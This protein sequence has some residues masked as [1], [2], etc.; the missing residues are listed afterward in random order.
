MEITTENPFR[1]LNDRLARLE[2]TLDEIKANQKKDHVDPN[3]LL[4]RKQIK[5]SYNISYPTLHKLMHN[6]FPY[7]KEGRKTLFRKGDVDKYFEN[8]KVVL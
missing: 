7:I 1:V 8:K 3:K 2:V 6:G 4:T 5:E